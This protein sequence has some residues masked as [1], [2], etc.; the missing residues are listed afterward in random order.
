[1]FH[2][3]SEFNVV[4]KKIAQRWMRAAVIGGTLAFVLSIDNSGL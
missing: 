2:G 1:M 4:D 3:A